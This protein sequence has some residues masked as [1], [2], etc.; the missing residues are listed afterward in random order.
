MQ[1][2]V[3]VLK[4]YAV[5]AV[6]SS[7]FSKGRQVQS[8]INLVDFAFQWQD[9]WIMEAMYL[10]FSSVN[11]HFNEKCAS[12]SILWTNSPLFYYLINF[13]SQILGS[14]K[15]A[16]SVVLYFS[17]TLLQQYYAPKVKKQ[18]NSVVYYYIH[19]RVQKVG[20]LGGILQHTYT[21]VQK[22]GKLGGIL[23]LTY[24]GP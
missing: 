9:L 10:P 5:Y 4:L 22:V 14:K 23:L 16:N 13:T 19:T 17:S 12:P 1:Q 21:R 20:K 8:I 7:A 3:Y 2:K 24:K 15:Q 6:L 18:A 11:T